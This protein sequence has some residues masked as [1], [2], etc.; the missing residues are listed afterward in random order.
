MELA[1]DDLAA[2][3]HDSVSN[4]RIHRAQLLVRLCSSQFDAGQCNDVVRVVAHL[5]VG[6]LVIVDSPLC[7]NTVVGINR[8]LKFAKKVR[9]NSEFLF[10]HN[11]L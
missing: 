10:V 6:N 1:V 5:S 4:L 2:C 7:L 3:L 8:N 9:F 11:E